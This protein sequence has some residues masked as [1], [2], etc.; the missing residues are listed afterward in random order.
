MEC[1]PISEM[2][3]FLLSLVVVACAV[4][5]KQIRRDDTVINL[6]KVQHQLESISIFAVSTER[7]ITNG[8]THS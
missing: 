2:K 7:N 5:Q 6:L 3:I 8:A 1:I 4:A